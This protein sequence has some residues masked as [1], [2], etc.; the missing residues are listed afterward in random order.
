LMAKYAGGKKVLGI[1]TWRIR[2]EVSNSD[3][4]SFAG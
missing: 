2:L 1:F 4:L 3:Q